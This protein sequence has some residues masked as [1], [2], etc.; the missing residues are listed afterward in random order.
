MD[1]FTNLRNKFCAGELYGPKTAIR[2]H[3]GQEW[4]EKHFFLITK[5]LISPQKIYIRNEICV[6]LKQKKILFFGKTRFLHQK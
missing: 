2:N 5:K 3:I 4:R 1:I 6:E